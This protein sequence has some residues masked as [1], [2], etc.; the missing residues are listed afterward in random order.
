[1]EGK[2]R[3]RGGGQRNSGSVP[4]KVEEGI[5][6]KI[7]EPVERSENGK[8]DA[9]P[10]VE[11]P[12]YSM[13]ELGQYLDN[14]KPYIVTPSYTNPPREDLGGVSDYLTKNYKVRVNLTKDDISSVEILDKTGLMITGIGVLGKPEEL[15]IM[16]IDFGENNPLIKGEALFFATPEGVSMYFFD[17]STGEFSHGLANLYGEGLSRGPTKVGLDITKESI[18]LLVIPD[19]GNTAAQVEI[20]LV[21]NSEYKMGYSYTGIF[22]VNR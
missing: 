19:A 5:A 11:T 17:K 13:G 9:V 12:T 20:G 10:Q 4:V 2:R 3:S 1:M 14:A 22:G 15:T 18:A 16:A 6:S 21:N 8:M 7:P